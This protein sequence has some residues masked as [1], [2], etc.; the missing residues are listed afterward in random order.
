MKKKQTPKK[1]QIKCQ[2]CTRPAKTKLTDR[3]LCDS[4]FI[5]LCER[6]LRRNLRKYSLQKDE[7]IIFLN[8]TDKKIFSDLIKI[9]LKLVIRDKAIAKKESETKIKQ[10]ARTALPLTLDDS[11]EDFI[12]EIFNHNKNE[13]TNKKDSK[14]IIRLY[15]PLTRT[16]TAAY[17]AIKGLKK[18]KEDIIQTELGAMLEE[19]ERKYPGTKTSIAQSAK[20]FKQSTEKKK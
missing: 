7:T 13:K 12:L 1:E 9:P 5:D 6:K 20:E 16:E 3:H 18:S 2:Q 14:N 8:Q 19:F 11:N 4:C 17:L 15:A 10:K